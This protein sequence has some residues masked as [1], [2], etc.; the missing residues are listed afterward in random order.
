MVASGKCYA[1]RAGQRR[2]HRPT[3]AEGVHCSRRRAQPAQ[4]QPMEF[5]K[6]GL[7]VAV[8]TVALSLPYL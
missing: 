2:G 3:R 5:T 7:V 6:Y 4:D 8:I 1:S